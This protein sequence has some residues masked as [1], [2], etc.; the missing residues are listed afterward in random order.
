MGAMY[1]KSSAFLT[2]LELG[3]FDELDAHYHDL[4]LLCYK[5]GF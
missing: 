2:V 5:L 4:V 3:L 1:I